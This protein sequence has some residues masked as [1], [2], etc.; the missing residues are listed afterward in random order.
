MRIAIGSDHAGFDQKEQLRDHLVAQGHDVEDL[1]TDSAEASV[2]YPDYAAAVAKSVASGDTEMGVLV[3][4]TGM[5]MAI[6]ANKVEGVRAV[7]VT[8]PEFAR[9]AREHNNANIVAVSGRFT[10]VEVNKEILDA[11]FSA[12]FEGGRHSAR[13]DKITK[14]EHPGAG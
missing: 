5:G 4:G 10:P 7:N 1:G 14:A 12:Q 11:F 13:V 3:C 2:D 9:L 6:A 8:S